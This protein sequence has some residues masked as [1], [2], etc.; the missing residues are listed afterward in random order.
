MGIIQAQT[1]SHSVKARREKVGAPLWDF[2]TRGNVAADRLVR[3]ERLV[4]NSKWKDAIPEGA[5]PLVWAE[6]DKATR[7][8]G[9]IHEVIKT[10]ALDS[11]AERMRNQGKRGQFWR[12]LENGAWSCEV[13][14]YIGLNMKARDRQ[15]WVRIATNTMRT[16]DLIFRHKGTSGLKAERLQAIHK[17][18]Q[19]KL[20]G[21]QE[22]QT[23]Y[24]TLIRCQGMEKHRK[25]IGDKYKERRRKRGDPHPEN[26]FD[27]VEK[28]LASGQEQQRAIHELLGMET[29]AEWARIPQ[30]D[31]NQALMVSL[32]R[33]STGIRAIHQ[34]VIISERK[35]K[36][37]Y[38]REL[39]QIRKAERKKKAS[40]EEKKKYNL[41]KK[42]I[43]EKIKQLLRRK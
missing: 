38:R 22:E 25:R 24:H 1:Q 13:T 34:M 36:R 41:E 30:G 4:E 35:H 12:E 20:C 28:H 10:K 42:T 5:K 31:R 17:D 6:P 2:L 43:R 16:R 37:F 32:R 18:G 14:K 23:L 21:A 7:Y 9:L 27:R 15:K 40:E 39:E 26:P 11:A 8:E 33:A 29:E 3:Q 19:C